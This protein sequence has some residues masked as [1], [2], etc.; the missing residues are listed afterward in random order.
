MLVERACFRPPL[1]GPRGRMDTEPPD[2]APKRSNYLASLR[3]QGGGPGQRRRRLNYLPQGGQGRAAPLRE[4]RQRG[5][6][7]GEICRD[8]KELR[9]SDPSRALNLHPPTGLRSG[10]QHLGGVPA[11]PYRSEVLRIGAPPGIR[12]GGSSK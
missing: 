6:A 2:R 5:G 10:R 7:S 9:A 12:G 8:Q 1:S 4:R 11:P 3:G